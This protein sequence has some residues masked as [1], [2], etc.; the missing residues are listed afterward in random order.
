MLG[1]RPILILARYVPNQ[2]FAQGGVVGQ[3]PIA[4]LHLS[5][6]AEGLSSGNSDLHLTRFGVCPFYSRCELISGFEGTHVSQFVPAY[7][8]EGSSPKVVGEPPPSPARTIHIVLL[9]LN[10]PSGVEFRIHSPTST[11]KTSAQ[12]VR[13]PTS[14]LHTW[15]SRPVTRLEVDLTAFDLS[16]PIVTEIAIKQGC[17]Q[18]R[19]RSTAVPGSKGLCR[20]FMDP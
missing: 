19:P 9:I 15:P 6:K 8:N 10:F 14:P 3:D 4:H 1:S 17:F 16:A 5:D 7:R 11:S 2:I 18:S 12:E 20:G 13:R